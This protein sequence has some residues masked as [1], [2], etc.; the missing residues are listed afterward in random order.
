[1]DNIQQTA[2]VEETTA[3][4]KKTRR[5]RKAKRTLAGAFALSIGLTGAG[6]LA[7]ALTPDA[8]IATAQKMTRLSSKRVRTSTMS[9]VL[10]A[11][12]QTF[13]VLRAAVLP[14]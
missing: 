12:V 8:Q 13:R 14:S 2:A 4:A 9:L 3:A 5:R 10:L 6:V 7:S 1:M 11:T